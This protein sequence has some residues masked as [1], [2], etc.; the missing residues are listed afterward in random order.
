MAKKFLVA[1]DVHGS[2][3]ALDNILS[4][5]D[6]HRVDKI[7]LLGDIFGVNASE[8]VE[9]LN[10]VANKLTIVKGNNDWYFEP[11]NAKFKIFEQTYENL[12][13]KLAYICHGHRLNDMALEMYGAKIILQG[14]IHRP[15]IEERNGI[16]RVC[17]G[18]IASPRFGSSK[19]Y[20]IVDEKKISIFDLDGGLVDETLY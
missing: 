11:E 18:S 1:A 10:N 17:P 9:K 14:H 19:C 3:I 20:A 8:M 2:M 6:E 12:N 4:L 16:I 13:G 7:I 5:A 15:F